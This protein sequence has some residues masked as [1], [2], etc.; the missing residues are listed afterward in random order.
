MAVD[1]KG[2]E[3]EAGKKPTPSEETRLSKTSSKQSTHLENVKKSYGESGSDSSSSR[4]PSPLVRRDIPDSKVPARLPRR[5][6]ESKSEESGTEDSTSAAQGSMVN[7]DYEGQSSKPRSPKQ[8]QERDR[9]QRV[10][11]G[12]N[13]PRA[14]HT[15]RSRSGSSEREASRRHRRRSRSSERRDRDRDRSSRSPE[16][17]S[18]RRDRRG[19]RASSSSPRPDVD[20]AIL[21]SKWARHRDSADSSSDEDREL[22][23]AFQSKGRKVHS[24]SDSGDVF[25]IE[26]LSQEYFS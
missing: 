4:T 10:P 15:R 14:R 1:G 23:K 11:E 19:K 6:K 16:R 21:P 2:T 9:R 26:K 12:D 8:A 18:R 13:P 7:R 22:E 24:A 25:G 17:S 5:T 20:P 3:I